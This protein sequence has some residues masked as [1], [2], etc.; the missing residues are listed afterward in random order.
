MRSPE[1]GWFPGPA[2]FAL[3]AVVVVIAALPAGAQARAAKGNAPTAR[4]CTTAHDNGGRLERAG[5]LRDAR[6]MM[7]VCG[8]PTCKGINNGFLRRDCLLRFDRLS[9][10]IPS[11][12]PLLVDEAGQPV[13]DARVSMDGHALASP[14]GVAVPM[15]PGVHELTFSR[16]GAVVGKQSVV[17]A[18][19][20]QN[21]RLQV[22]MDGAGGE[23]APPTR[24]D[25][26]RAAGKTDGSPDEP[27]GETET[28]S[29]EREA[30]APQR[31]A[32]GARLTFGSV[33]LGTIALG[34]AG[35]FALLTYWGRKD[36][37]QLSQCAPHCPSTGVDRIQSLYRYA[38]IA[39]AVGAV[40]LVGAIWIYAT[41]ASPAEVPE[42]AHH[43][44][45]LGVSLLPSP[46]GG[47]AMLF[48]SF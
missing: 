12:V 10:D 48:G 33:A 20:E 27:H 26:D 14:A 22:T 4:Q 38:D 18:Q 43:Q 25:A 23:A 39:G 17:V 42:A 24:A 11:V 16:G 15:D 46:T 29:D 30:P 37:A 7:T 5:R 13:V 31:Q 19:G 3:T 28:A 40:A 6:E 35:G 2:A 9:A 32:R 45:A 21:R 34:G 41:S 44:S 36:N 1:T 8:Q 47:G